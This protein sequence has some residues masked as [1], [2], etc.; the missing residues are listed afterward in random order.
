MACLPSHL[1]IH[2]SERGREGNGGDG[3]RGGGREGEREGRREGGKWRRRE[4]DRERK[5]EVEKMEREM[6]EGGRC[7][8]EIVSKTLLQV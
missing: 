7:K 4:G 2:T 1:H 5:K 6:G 8:G 3:E